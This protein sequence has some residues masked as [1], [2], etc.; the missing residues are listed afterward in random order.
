MKTTFLIHHLLKWASISLKITTNKQ[1]RNIWVGQRHV[2]N[3]VSFLFLRHKYLDIKC[4]FQII[5]GFLHVCYDINSHF[6]SKY[7]FFDDQNTRKLE[8]SRENGIVIIYTRAQFLFS[9]MNT[10]PN[11]CENE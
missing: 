6:L 11:L 8:N 3:F 2:T 10:K 7:M 9:N 5:F 1:F 4:S